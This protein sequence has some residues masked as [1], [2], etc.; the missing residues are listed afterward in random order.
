MKIVA[1]NHADSL[2]RPGSWDTTEAAE[3]VVLDSVRDEL[4]S[5]Y[6][7]ADDALPHALTALA[8]Q[9]DHAHAA[10]NDRIG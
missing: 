10:G 6:G 3:V 1:A 8:R 2:R 5:V 7:E 9:L 4:R